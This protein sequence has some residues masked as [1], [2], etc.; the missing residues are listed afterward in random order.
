MMAMTTSSS[1]NVKPLRRFGMEWLFRTTFRKLTK[2]VSH[3]NWKPRRRFTGAGANP[4]RPN[5][6]SGVYG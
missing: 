1:I 2:I 5:C 3:G 6:R 4:P